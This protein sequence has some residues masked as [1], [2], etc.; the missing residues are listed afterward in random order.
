[1]KA[2]IV[3]D[4]GNIGFLV[5]P[6]VEIDSCRELMETEEV[7]IRATDAIMHDFMVDMHKIEKI[8][9]DL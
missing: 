5:G 4:D 3:M 6:S 1:M 7:E 9:Q 2:S 8:C